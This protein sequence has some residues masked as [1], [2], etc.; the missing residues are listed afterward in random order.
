M[1]NVFERA[2]PDSSE[3]LALCLRRIEVLEADKLKAQ[4]QLRLLVD[5]ARDELA[6]EFLDLLAAMRQMKTEMEELKLKLEVHG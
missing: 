5:A 1:V 4:E 3:L 6:R 2:A